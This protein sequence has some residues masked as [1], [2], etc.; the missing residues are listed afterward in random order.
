MTAA[1]ISARA[2]CV[3]TIDRFPQEQLPNLAK[4]LERLVEEALDDAF[5]I[6]LAERHSLRPD[7]DEPG[8]SLESFAAELGIVLGEEHEN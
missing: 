7:K 6:S 4:L 5:C 1:A 3:N 8:I 2:H